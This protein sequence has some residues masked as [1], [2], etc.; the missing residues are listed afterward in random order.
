M[1]ERGQQ[2]V[3]SSTADGRARITAERLSSLVGACVDCGNCATKEHLDEILQLRA[4]RIQHGRP[5]IHGSQVDCPNGERV[6]IEVSVSP[7][8]SE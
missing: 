5:F 3:R 6:W 7:S 8:T 1:F 2:Q 4:K